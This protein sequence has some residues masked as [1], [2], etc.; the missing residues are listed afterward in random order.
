MPTDISDA[1][2]KETENAPLETRV[3]AHRPTACGHP[4][5]PSGRRRGWAYGRADHSSRRRDELITAGVPHHKLSDVMGT[6][7]DF[8]EDLAKLAAL[9]TERDALGRFVADSPV[10][11]TAY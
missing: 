2:R 10:Y 6:A 3:R 4:A 7:Y 9:E 5:R 11:D 1:G 8:T